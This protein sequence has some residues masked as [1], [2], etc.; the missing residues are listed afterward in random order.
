MPLTLEK[1]CGVSHCKQGLKPGI[2]VALCG[3]AEAVP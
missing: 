2:V 3:T 1:S